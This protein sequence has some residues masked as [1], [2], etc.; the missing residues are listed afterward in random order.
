[1]LIDMK[2]GSKI[3]AIINKCIYC[4]ST[5]N[6]SDEHIIPYGL[7]GNL[8]LAKASCQKCG[9]ITSRFE[10]DVLRKMFVTLRSAQNLPTRGM[11]PSRFNTKVLLK[12]KSQEETV[13]LLPEYL[14]VFFPLYKPPAFFDGRPVINGIQIEGHHSVL[15]SHPD[16]VKCL[17]EEGI[18]QLKHEIHFACGSFERLLSKIAYCYAVSQYGLDGIKEKIILPVILGHDTEFNKY[19]GLDNLNDIPVTSHFHRIKLV[20]RGNLILGYVQLFGI[21]GSPYY[22]IV[23]GRK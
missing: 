7:G 8:V 22:T 20:E 9:E 18:T 4:N 5:E 19:V 12:D 17:N 6:L 16:Q 2:S 3:L 1:M 14:P 21:F 10:L 13:P 23:I 15:M 11:L